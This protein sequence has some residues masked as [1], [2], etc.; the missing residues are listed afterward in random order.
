MTVYALHFALF[1]RVALPPSLL[2]LLLHFLRHLPPATFGPLSSTLGP[3][4]AGSLYTLFLAAP[5]PYANCSAYTTPTSLAALR[6]SLTA[7][8]MPGSVTAECQASGRVAL[9]FMP[10]VAAARQRVTAFLGAYELGT[11]LEGLDVRPGPADVARTRLASGA[12]WPGDTEAGMVWPRNAGWGGVGLGREGA[13]TTGERA[14]TSLAS[15]K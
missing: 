13:M 15:G 14:C 1:P 11:P 4:Q 10:T 7:E 3:A 9:S 12:S 2:T 5:A 6:V 8:P